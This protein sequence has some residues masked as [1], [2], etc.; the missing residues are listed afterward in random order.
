MAGAACG[1]TFKSVGHIWYPFTYIERM[2][3]ISTV[4]YARS[5]Y[6]TDS[7]GVGRV[8]TLGEKS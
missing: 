2:I 4:P 7:V 6:G 8:I 1:R 3:E 5:D